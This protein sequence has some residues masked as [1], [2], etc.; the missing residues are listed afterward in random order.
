MALYTKR[1]LTLLVARDSKYTN[2][3]VS[4]DRATLEDE[5]AEAVSGEVIIGAS[6]TYTVPMT[7]AVAT[8]QLL[9][10]E[11]DRPVKL[12]FDGSSDKIALAPSAAGTG[13]M[14]LLERGSFT[15]LTVENEDA[16]NAATV[17]YAVLGV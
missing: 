4:R 8:G 12:A 5:F 7:G 17:F 13:A 1:I 14:A 6:T 11:F 15:S 3:L 10:I 2:L 9:Y 16:S